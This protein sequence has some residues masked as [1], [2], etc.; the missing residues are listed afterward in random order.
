MLTK[1]TKGSL[2][3]MTKEHGPVGRKNIFRNIH[4][5]I[6]C[7]WAV[8]Y[9]LNHS[10]LFNIDVSNLFEKEYFWFLSVKAFFD[11]CMNSLRIHGFTFSAITV[12]KWGVISMSLQSVC[13]TCIIERFLFWCVNGFKGLIVLEIISMMYINFIMRVYLHHHMFTAY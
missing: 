2:M 13:L 9:L 5:D 7:E 4:T 1:L 12:F 3:F 11:F 6:I 8:S 10:T